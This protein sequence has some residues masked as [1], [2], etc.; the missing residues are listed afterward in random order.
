MINKI[1]QLNIAFK[2]VR[3]RLSELNVL[4]TARHSDASTLIITRFD[5]T[6]EWRMIFAIPESSVIT[7]TYKG[8][9]NI[10]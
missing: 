5:F 10:P 3:A 7:I 8:C 1:I 6:S 9:E 2:V 4:K